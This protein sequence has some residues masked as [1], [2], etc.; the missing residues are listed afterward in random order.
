[1]KSLKQ[2]FMIFILCFLCAFIIVL[3]GTWRCKNKSFTDPLTETL[4]GGESMKSYTDGW[5]LL[6]FVFYAFLTYLYPKY[7]IPIFIMG[8][9]WE[10]IESMS[11]DTPFYLT[12]CNTEIDSDKQKAWWYGRWQDIVMNTL[13][14][15]FGYILYKYNIS[16]LIFPFLY[17]LIIGYSFYKAWKND[18][19]YNKK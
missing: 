3:Y 17:F 18:K 15:L 8:V 13:G 1:M 14:Q 2:Y 11:K 10:I 7:V 12:S 6:H 16:F 5:G 19:L 4:I 9:I